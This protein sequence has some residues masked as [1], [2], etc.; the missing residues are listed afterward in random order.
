MLEAE[1]VTEH[2]ERRIQS[3]THSLD[4]VVP[5]LDRLQVRLLSA[6]HEQVKVYPVYVSLDAV[7]R[8]ADGADRCN[9]QDEFITRLG[10]LLGSADVRSVI[11]SLLAQATEA[12]AEAPAS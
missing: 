7:G 11:E 6:Q 2:D 8:G 4:L 12:M 1:V 5:A 10:N 9:S 3:V